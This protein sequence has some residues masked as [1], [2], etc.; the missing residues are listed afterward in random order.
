MKTIRI[1]PKV[2]EYA[3][4]EIRR[5]RRLFEEIGMAFLFIKNEE[6]KDICLDI[7]VKIDTIL[8]LIEELANGQKNTPS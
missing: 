7:I 6:K 3:V 2:L 1:N 5:T 4:V 8:D